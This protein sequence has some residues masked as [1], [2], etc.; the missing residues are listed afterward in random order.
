MRVHVL[1][2]LDSLAEHRRCDTASHLDYLQTTKYVSLGVCEGL[3]LLQDDGV[4][5][6][7]HVI[8][9]EGLQPGEGEAREQEVE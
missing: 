1:G 2:H 6:V 9:Q 4:G 5:N 8:A 7:V 3:A